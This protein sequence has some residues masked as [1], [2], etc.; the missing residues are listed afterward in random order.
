M[1]QA[2]EGAQPHHQRAA[3]DGH[4]APVPE[5]ARERLDGRPI[6]RATEHGSEYDSVADV[7]VR[8]GRGQ[9]LAAAIQR[10]WHGQLDYP[11][12]PPVAQPQRPQAL[13]V[14]EQRRV[15]DVGGNPER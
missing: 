1:G 2:V 7:E 6:L 8:G 3:V 13:K 10:F 9:T 12:R 14:V 15:V 5:A 11:Y 4:D